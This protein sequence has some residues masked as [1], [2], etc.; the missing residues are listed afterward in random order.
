MKIPL[1]LA[2]TL[3]VVGLTGCRVELPPVESAFV[4]KTWI[5]ADSSNKTELSPAQID[6]LKTWFD[7][8][9]DGWKYQ[10]ADINPDTFLLFRP[11]RGREAWVYLNGNQLW[12]RNYVRSLSTE[13]RAALDSILKPSD[14]K[15]F[16]A[17]R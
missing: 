15:A 16:P 9:Q 7:A 6:A 14:P 12:V 13:E 17:F 10:V 5:K 3:T 1:A 11:K 8:R 2:L 4:A